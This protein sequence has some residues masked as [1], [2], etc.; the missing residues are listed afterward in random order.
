[1]NQRMWR[2]IYHLYKFYNSSVS[3]VTK[4][5]SVLVLQDKICIINSLLDKHFFVEFKIYELVLQI[6]IYL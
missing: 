1:M 5:N 2:V 4:T 3:C 6:T